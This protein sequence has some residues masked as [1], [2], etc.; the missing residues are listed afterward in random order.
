MHNN[1]VKRI[2]GL[3]LFVKDCQGFGHPGLCVDVHDKSAIALPHLCRHDLRWTRAD[4]LTGLVRR[5]GLCDC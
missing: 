1:G 3:G 2:A 5:S 4:F